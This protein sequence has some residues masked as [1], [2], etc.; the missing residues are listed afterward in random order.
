[1]LLLRYVRLKA[2]ASARE[3]RAATV[4]HFREANDSLR[5]L[6]A[7]VCK[8]A[9]ELFHVRQRLSKAHAALL[10]EGILRGRCCRPV[11]LGAA[12]AGLSRC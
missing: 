7:A 1:M 6:R 3:R 4:C 12:A 10:L 8:K 5:R 11:A 2:E 9:K